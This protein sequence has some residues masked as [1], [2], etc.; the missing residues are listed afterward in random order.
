M[1]SGEGDLEIEQM[2]KPPM[3]TVHRSISYISLQEGQHA[4]VISS[5]SYSCRYSFR[6][7]SSN[8]FK[9]HVLQMH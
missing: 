7:L 2:V 5:F 1:L 3:T 9:R 4:E 6:K 8:V